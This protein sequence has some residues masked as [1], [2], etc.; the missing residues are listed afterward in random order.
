MVAFRPLPEEL[1]APTGK[2]LAVPLML[3]DR[4]GD[5]RIAESWE[6]FDQL[7]ML[8][9]LGAIPAATAV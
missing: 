1:L 9:A 5:G 3:I 7:G 8:Q 4:L 2:A 6:A